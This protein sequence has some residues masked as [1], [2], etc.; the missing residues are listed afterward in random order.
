MDV[1]G[2]EGDKRKV[3]FLGLR[4]VDFYCGFGGFFTVPV[5][6]KVNFDL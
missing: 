6:F 3:L 5:P 2:A 4:E 1:A